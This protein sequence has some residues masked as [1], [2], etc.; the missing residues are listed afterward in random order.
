MCISKGDEMPRELRVWA[1]PGEEQKFKDEII[2]MI[3]DNPSPVIIP[4]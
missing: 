2:I 1:I 4:I 3:K